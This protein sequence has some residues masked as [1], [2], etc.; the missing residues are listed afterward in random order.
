MYILY[1]HVLTPKNFSHRLP[2]DPMIITSKVMVGKHRDIA[3]FLNFEHLFLIGQTCKNLRHSKNV[4][5]DQ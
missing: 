4:I 1:S 2:S 5:L 3:C